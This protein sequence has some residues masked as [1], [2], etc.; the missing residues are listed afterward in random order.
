MLAA[1]AEDEGVRA[2]GE[3]APKQLGSSRPPPSSAPRPAPRRAGPARRRHRSA[4]RHPARPGLA[5]AARPPP[6]LARLPAPRRDG[7][8]R[9]PP[10]AHPGSRCPSA[11]VTAKRWREAG[12]PPASPARRRRP[13]SP[14]PLA[15]FPLLPRLQPPA[16][17]PDLAAGGRGRQRSCGKGEWTSRADTR[18]GEG[19][20]AAGEAAAPLL[21]PAPRTAGQTGEALQR[22][23]GRSG[24]RARAETWRRRRQAGGRER[25]QQQEQA[26][27]A[28]ALTLAM[29]GGRRDGQTAPG[30][31]PSW[32]KAVR[33]G[34]SGQWG[35]AGAGC[36]GEGRGGA[37]GAGAGL[38]RADGSGARGDCVWPPRNGSS[39]CCPA[40]GLS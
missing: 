35:P 40:W 28:G 19:E 33:D 22:H 6:P 38:G 29:P 18:R 4:P 17:L 10:A 9:C 37:G 7:H 1:F 5:W 34:R 26:G 30:G 31:G 8:R 16:P 2:D 25:E 20:V 3:R 11:A 13:R 39:R 27:A 14:P 23:G 32:G 24:S 12:W 15:H 36:A 21:L